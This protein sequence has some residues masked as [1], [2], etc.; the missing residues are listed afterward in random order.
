MHTFTDI[1]RVSYRIL[2]LLAPPPLYETLK[3]I[4]SRGKQW[5]I[6]PGEIGKEDVKFFFTLLGEVQC[7]SL[8]D[9]NK[10]LSSPLP[11]K[12]LIFGGFLEPMHERGLSDLEHFISYSV[13]QLW[14]LG[15]SL[16][17]NDAN[18]ERKST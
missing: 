4:L 8:L 2:I 9:A 18:V 15:F 11:D 14:S 12:F 17:S 10:F 3:I 6:L 1:P 13:R 7:I 16:F 5:V